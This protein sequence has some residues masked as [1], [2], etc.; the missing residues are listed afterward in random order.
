MGT[1]HTG[2]I[3]AITNTWSSAHLLWLAQCSQYVAQRLLYVTHACRLLN[4]HC[5]V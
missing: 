5:T 2:S 1:C 4:A 3:V